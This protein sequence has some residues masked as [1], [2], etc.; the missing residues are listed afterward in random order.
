MPSWSDERLAQLQHEWDNADFFKTLPETAAFERACARD[1]CE[2]YR[3]QP[4]GPGTPA[5]LLAKELFQRPGAVV[6]E[7]KYRWQEARYRHYG[8]FEDE[9]A[10]MLFDRDRE[11]E[12][13]RAVESPTWE[14]MR[15]F[16]GATNR[17]VFQSKFSSRLQMMLSRRQGG[18]AFQRGG[19]TLLGRAAE[20]EARRRILV[21]AIALE[22]HRL[23][24]GAYPK[25]LDELAPALLKQ[26]PLDFIDGKPLRYRLTQ[27][28]HF[29][30]Y[31]LG[32]D[33]VDNGGRLSRVS[34]PGL[35]FGGR[36]P[37]VGP[38]GG[39]PL[40]GFGGGGPFMGAGGGRRFGGPQA[41]ELV[42]PR[43]ASAA[44]AELVHQEQQKAA[45]RQ[46]GDIEDLQANAWWDHTA[47]RQAK[48]EKI[49]AA[50]PAPLTNEPA[51]R[52]RPLSD[53][54][55]NPSASGTNKPA[56]MEMLTLKQVL[57]GDEPETATFEL[58]VRYDALT[59]VGSLNLYI[60]P[61]ED[62]DSDEGAHVGQFECRRATNGN[63][64][65]VLNT[66]FEAPG[67]HALLAEL[68]LDERTRQH[69]EVFGPF[70]P[71]VVSNLCQLSSTSATFDPNTGAI[72]HLKLPEPRGT[73]II[74]INS[75]S[76]E[77]LKTLS[78]TTTNGII[79]EHWN[80]IDDHG[81]RFRGNAFDTLFHL[82]LPESGRS[83]TFKGP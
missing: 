64:L 23:R 68:A 19:G 26:P 36:G 57:T 1:A 53:L 37:L 10:A 29:V 77:R 28:G 79:K 32:L 63:S 74:E 59:N 75:P 51:Y 7:L 31:S 67:K 78:G 27:D 24:H 25:S 4:G 62:D 12:L 83:R 52:G 69:Q 40:G 41:P 39:G 70:T 72:L 82:T 2:R 20:A 55:S 76:G 73:C 33:G 9:K 46:A 61:C 13:R 22:R 49:L 80:L 8:S 30:L 81:A 65:L 66:L 11:I 56:L 45:E 58:P 34:Q 35:P 43:P 54:L 42:W 3:L 5:G 44:E 50:P 16:P 18:L 17:A 48:V 47:R 38:G 21:T 71:L 60:D 14:Q 6:A 15:Q